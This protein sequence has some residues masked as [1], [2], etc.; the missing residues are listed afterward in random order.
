MLPSFFTR[1]QGLRKLYCGLFTPMLERR[2]LTQLEVDIL[3]F[4]ANN[5]A[6]DTARDIVERRHLAKSHVSAGIEALAGRGLLE[7]W[8]RADNRKTIHLRLTEAAGPVVAEGRAVQRQY[9]GAG[10][11][12]EASGEDIGKRGSRPAPIPLRPLSR[13]VRRKDGTAPPQKSKI[14]PLQGTP[15]MA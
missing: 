8:K 15:P 11:A 1:S 14:S 10:G 3:L 9:G 5:P 13:R 4:L 7:R 6:Y 12:G 2:A